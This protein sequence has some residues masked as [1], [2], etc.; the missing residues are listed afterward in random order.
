[1]FKSLPTA[2]QSQQPPAQQ[3]AK[4]QALQPNQGSHLVLRQSELPLDPEEDLLICEDDSADRFPRCKTIQT[5]AHQHLTA[6]NRC[7][8]TALTNQPVGG[9]QLP[10]TPQEAI[11]ALGTH[12]AEGNGLGT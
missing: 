9:K 1:M 6:V 7:I 10:P 5:P 4:D 12:L 8:A 2:L 11:Q 3:Q